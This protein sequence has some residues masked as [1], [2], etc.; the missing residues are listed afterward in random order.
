MQVS[1]DRQAEGAFVMF[2][3]IL[4]TWLVL[5]VLPINLAVPPPGR[6]PANPPNDTAGT[7]ERTFASDD[8]FAGITGEFVKQA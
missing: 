6:L 8:P 1:P 5:G 4:S 3:R 2:E 7:V